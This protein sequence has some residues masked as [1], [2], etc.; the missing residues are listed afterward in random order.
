MRTSKDTPTPQ[1]KTLPISSPLK[2]LTSP[3]KASPV[4]SQLTSKDASINSPNREQG[5]SVVSGEVEGT[6]SNRWKGD[7]WNT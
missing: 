3:E 2:S 6:T 7:A 4:L 1:G 5:E